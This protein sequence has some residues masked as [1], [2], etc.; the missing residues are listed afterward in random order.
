MRM[1]ANRIDS[2]GDDNMATDYSGTLSSN[3]G[4]S[5]SWNW[6]GEEF[7]LQKGSNF[8]MSGSQ[9]NEVILNEE[10]LSYMLDDETTPVKS[11][12]DLAYQATHSGKMSKDPKEHRETYSQ[13]KRRRMLQF[14]PQVLDSSLCCDEMPSAFQKSNEREDSVEEVL[15][16]VSQWTTGLSGLSASNCD[17]LDSFEGWIAECLNDPEMT[18]TPDDMN[19][20]EAS[21]IQIDISEFCNSTNSLPTCNTNVVQQQ[22][23][24]TPRNVFFKGRKSLL[25][26][27]TKLASS[28]AYP[29][30][31]IKPCGIHGDVT[32]NDINQRIH[33]P[34]SK[35]KQNIDDPSAYPTSAFS[36]K[37][38]V[39]KTKIHT[40]GGKGS[41]T[42]MRTK[43]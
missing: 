19:F 25:R 39:G 37:P 42:I 15:P 3:P 12:G 28:V 36:G 2:H 10:D 40:E 24:R 6:Q 18:F 26:T 30:A 31:F 13:A 4:D 21:D 14:D 8:D 16:G 11:C 1:S 43:G 20:S 41:I 7:C 17:G 23:T 38:V 27:P 5:K 29:F 9:F 34:G 32:L 22:V 35:T 33:S